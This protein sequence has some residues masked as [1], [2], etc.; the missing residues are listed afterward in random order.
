MAP[1][2]TPAQAWQANGASQFIPAPV[3]I[4]GTRNYY[5]FRN[6]HAPQ[7]FKNETNKPN[8]YINFGL[9]FFD[10]MQRLR[11]GANIDLINFIDKTALALQ[12]AL[13]NA[14]ADDPSIENHR[15][16]LMNAA[17]DTHDTVYRESGF[18]DLTTGEQLEILEVV[19]PG[20]F[21]AGIGPGLRELGQSWDLIGSGFVNEFIYIFTPRPPQ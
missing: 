9:R 18:G 20:L 13:E 1:G 4:L 5:L 7:S 2:P 16:T 21:A 8:Y 11:E 6:Q 14:L 10:A 17:F 15:D 12:Q 19:A 3:N